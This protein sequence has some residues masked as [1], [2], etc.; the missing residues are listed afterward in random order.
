MS[1]LQP[2][3]RVGDLR[4]QRT[5]RDLRNA[6]LRLASE[7]GF[8][9]VTVGDIAARATVNRASFYRHYVDKE[10]LAVDVL[11]QKLIEL[12]RA[13]PLQEPQAAVDNDLRLDS[14]TQL[15][16][17]FAQH[18]RLYQPLFGYPRNRRFM[19]RVRELLSS[20]INERIRRVDPIAE[21]A[22]MP[23]E[24]VAVFTVETLLGVIAWWLDRGVPYPPRQMAAW[25]TLF[26]DN[27]YFNVLGL[28]HLTPD[29]PAARPPAR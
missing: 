25:F 14:G 9:A 19:I 2:A 21:Q 5:R 13:E 16:A 23:P 17:H 7:H 26:V 10:D 28:D 24:V 20:Q 3:E 11:A 27:G 15:F 18:R 6:L 8:D 1:R 4:V 12:A 22:R 29:P